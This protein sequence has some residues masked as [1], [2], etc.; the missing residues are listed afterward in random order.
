MPNPHGASSSPLP[1]VSTS[2]LAV[3]LE[4]ARQGSFTA[5]AVSLGYTQ[6]AISRQ[7]AALE[8]ELGGATLFDRLPRGVQ[9]TEPGRVLLPHAEALTERLRGVRRELDA[10]REV[11]GG[12]LR[13][14]AFP[15]ADAA[16]LPRAIAAFRARY[17][18]VELTRE[19]GL[20]AG[21][22]ARLDAGELD[23][24]VVSTTGG[25]A[26]ASYELHH[27][28]DESMYVALPADHRL[29]GRRRVRLAELADEDWISG[30]PRMERSLLGPAVRDGFHPRVA[31]VAAEWIAKQGY[32]A[33]GLGVALIPALAAESVRPDIALVAVHEADAPAR[34]VYA[35]TLR[36]R[37]LSPAA[38][39]F[40]GALREA[41]GGLGGASG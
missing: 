5:A 4:V 13:V 8:A 28:L 6:S 17:P 25:D 38:G 32:V 24:A 19:E 35:A 15:T 21:Q 27:L 41:V 16:L 40:L 3:F 18:G 23:L 22:L 2:W 31:H 29:A 30:S 39:A 34:A 10:L 11:S 12:R 33:A 1:E 7:I 36:G 26:L 20:T 9:L 37:S 14:G